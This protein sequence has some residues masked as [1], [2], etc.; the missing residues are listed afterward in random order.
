MPGSREFE[1]HFGRVGSRPG[2]RRT[3]RLAGGLHLA[4]RTRPGAACGTAERIDLGG[5]GRALE[6]PQETGLEVRRTDH[7]LR[8]YA[9][10]GA[11]QRSRRGL[12]DPGQGR[13]GAQELPAAGTLTHDL[14]TAGRGVAGRTLFGHR[15]PFRGHGRRLSA[16]SRAGVR[17][18]RIPIL[19]HGDRRRNGRS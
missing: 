10:D 16:P 6:G 9:G 7:G 12:R 1:F 13:A 17:L 18:R 14:P 5:I 8:L 2:S 15:T 11:D 4:L 3:G 19:K